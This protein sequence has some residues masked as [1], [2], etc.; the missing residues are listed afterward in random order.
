MRVFILC[1][2]HKLVVKVL[3]VYVGSGVAS[4][5]NYQ[6]GLLP[7]AKAS[8]IRLGFAHYFYFPQTQNRLL[9]MN[10][11]ILARLYKYFPAVGILR[12]YLTFLD[13]VS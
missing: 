7:K 12:R 1:S 8:N 5:H 11:E 3:E 6:H 2:V 9:C 4:N 10:V 13:V